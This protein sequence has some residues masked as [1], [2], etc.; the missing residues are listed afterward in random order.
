[1]SSENPI[2]NSPYEEPKYYYATDHE[3]N[4]DYSKKIK[5]RRIFTPDIQV[6]PSRQKE[7]RS[8]FEIGDFKSCH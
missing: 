4:L 5:G 7:Q 2:L 6:I 3:G 8:A 1:M